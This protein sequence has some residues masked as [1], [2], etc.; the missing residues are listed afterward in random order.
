MEE[1]SIGTVAAR[2][3]V[4]ASAIRYYEAQGLIPRGAR[5]GGRR[6]Y[7][8]E[9]LQRL[10]VIDLAKKAGFTVAETRRL[11]SGFS[12][13]TPPGARW[14]ALAERKLEE[15]DRRI[16]EA[17][18]MKTVLAALSACSCPSLDECARALDAQDGPTP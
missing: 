5:R 1:L 17:E 18:R 11:V 7:G 12:R 2:A 8:P 9:I 3:G 14:R 4:A 15:L 6:V 16:E 13:R 10:R